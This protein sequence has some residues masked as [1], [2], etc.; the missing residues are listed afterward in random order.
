MPGLIEVVSVSRAAFS[1]GI[2]DSILRL[3]GGRD[4]SN[5]RELSGR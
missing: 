2:A 4:S 5:L 3:G 1:N